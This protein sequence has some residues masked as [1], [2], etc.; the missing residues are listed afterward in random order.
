MCDGALGRSRLHLLT[1]AWL[2]LL[3]RF[4]GPPEAQLQLWLMLMGSV[5]VAGMNATNGT[6]DGSRLYD[7]CG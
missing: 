4:T 2:P 7:G 3:L 6:H 1:C 5:H